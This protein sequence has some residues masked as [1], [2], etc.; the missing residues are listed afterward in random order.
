MLVNYYLSGQ[1]CLYRAVALNRSA[2]M[3][4]LLI[5]MMLIKRLSEG[6][7]KTSVKSY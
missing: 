2:H 3:M 1:A 4:K 5:K 6:T 7:V